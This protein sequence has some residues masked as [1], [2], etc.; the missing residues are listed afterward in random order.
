MSVKDMKYVLDN[1]YN[2]REQAIFNDDWDRVDY[3][4][5]KIAEVDLQIKEQS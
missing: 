4:N 1:Y 2:E 3:L 5:K